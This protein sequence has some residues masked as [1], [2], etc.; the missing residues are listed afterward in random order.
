MSTFEWCEKTAVIKLPSSV[1]LETLPALLKQ[2][3]N[4]LSLPVQQVDFSLVQQADSAILA[5]LLIWSKNS[6]PESSPSPLKI[7][8][9]P[10]SLRGLIVLY[11]LESIVMIEES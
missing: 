6:A 10:N 7:V 4:S 3:K 11:D 1:T 2:A 5:L 8:A 9:L